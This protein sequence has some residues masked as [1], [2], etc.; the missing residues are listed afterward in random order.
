MD[1][2]LQRRL[3][4]EILN[5]GED[6]VWIDPNKLEEVSK[7]L[8]KQDIK[9]LINK[10]I[11]RKKQVKGQS[12]TWANYI[13]EKRKKG[14]RRGSGSRKGSK[15]TRT[16]PKEEWMKRIRALRRLLRKLR[17]EKIIDKHLYRELYIKAKAG[18]FKNKRHIL[19]FLRE[20]GILKEN[21]QALN[22]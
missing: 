12:R 13:H 9:D 3:A 22:K 2:S 15:K 19:L 10:G 6:R 21:Q 8:S 4:A 17:D 1:L 5:V 20:K 18:E 16:D 7:A 11:I 14:R